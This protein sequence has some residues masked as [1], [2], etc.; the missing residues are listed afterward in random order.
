MQLLNLQSFDVP[1]HPASERARKQKQEAAPSFT[2]AE[3]EAAKQEARRQGYEEGMHAGIASAKHEATETERRLQQA[4]EHVAQQ[5]DALHQSYTRH[6]AEQQ[7]VMQQLAATI[8]RKLAEHALKHAPLSEIEGL[9]QQ[10]LPLLVDQPSLTITVPAS[11]DAALK[12]KIHALAAEAKVTIAGDERM[13]AGD[14]R[15]AWKNGSVER[16]AA[17][18]WQQVETI[19]GVHA[20]TVPP[21]LRGG[22]KGEGD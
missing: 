9:L 3:L 10:T 18:I 20:V 17:A 21:P 15:I 16:N 12:E 11:L 7:P 19:L 1:G 5:C 6:L 14:A 8:A 2:A 22:G 4:L 13:S